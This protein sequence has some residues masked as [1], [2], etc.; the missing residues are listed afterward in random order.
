[1]KIEKTG[2]K[3]KRT[4]RRRNSRRKGSAVRLAGGYAFVELTKGHEAKIS[5]SDAPFVSAYFWHA[6]TPGK[7]I[8]AARR[9]PTRGI[10]LLH[11]ELMGAT[12]DQQVDHINGN[13]LD[14]TRGN[15]RLCSAAQNSWNKHVKQ[16]R[17][18]R[19][20]APTGVCFV[21]EIHASKP[22]LAYANLNRKRK[23]LGYHETMEQAAEA[24]ARFIATHAPQDFLGP[25]YKND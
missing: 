24:R 20:E 25:I 22:W 3:Q 13:T 23:Y 7:A 1:M 15:L 12:C 4:Q 19:P 21:P 17:R 9:D 11:R 6:A 14:N 16:P 2:A 5:I 8:Y 10:V 18:G